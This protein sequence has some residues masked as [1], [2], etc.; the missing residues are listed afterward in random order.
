MG[1]KISLKGLSGQ[2]EKERSQSMLVKIYLKF[3]VE[4]RRPKASFDKGACCT[5][6]L[7]VSASG[8]GF[9]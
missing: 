8:Y 5:K 3:T 1:I 4:K 9:F 2:G 6:A 7:F